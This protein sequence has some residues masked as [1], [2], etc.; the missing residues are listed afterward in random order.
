[1]IE[2]TSMKLCK[3]V[4]FMFCIFFYIKI[5]EDSFFLRVRWELMIN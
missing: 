4:K 3:G 2:M 5:P 1:V